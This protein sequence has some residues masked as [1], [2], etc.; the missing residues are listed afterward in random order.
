MQIWSFIKNIFHLQFYWN[1]NNMIIHS[2]C[3][4]LKNINKH[5]HFL[6]LL[7]NYNISTHFSSLEFNKEKMEYLMSQ[8]WKEFTTIPKILACQMDHII[9]SNPIW[10]GIGSFLTKTHPTTSMQLKRGFQRF[11]TNIIWSNKTHTLFMSP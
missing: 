10:K 7:D 4:T 2:M 3:L 11:Y 1:N 8:K 9:L 5:S 6:C